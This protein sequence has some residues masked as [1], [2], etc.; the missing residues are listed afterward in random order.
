[1]IEK[2]TKKTH[3]IVT[4][5]DDILKYFS[6]LSEKIRH[7]ISCERINMKHH[8]LFSSKDKSKEKHIVPSAASLLGH[9]QH[10]TNV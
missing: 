6:L 8:A 3:P 1:M 9:Y 5:E 2:I 4:A 7:E 10:K